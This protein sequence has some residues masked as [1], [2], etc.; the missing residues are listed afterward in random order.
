M[1]HRDYG[2]RPAARL[3]PPR[4]QQRTLRVAFPTA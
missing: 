1:F 2:M 4:L 3:P